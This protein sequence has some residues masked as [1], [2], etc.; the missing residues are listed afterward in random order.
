MAIISRSTFILLIFLS[1]I[2][3][4]FQAFGQ[5]NNYLASVNNKAASDYQFDWVKTDSSLTLK[6]HGET[7][8][9]FNYNNRFGKPYF[10]PLNVNG[11]SL[12]CVSPSDHPWH[13]GLW[14]SW[15]YIDG[16]NYWEYLDKYKSGETG[17]QSE[18]IT[19]IKKIKTI[20]H[21]DFSAD[22]QL[23]INYQAAGCNPALTE[24]RKLHLSA[25]SADGS[26]YIDQEHTF[27]ALSD[28]V[29]LDRTPTSGEPGGFAWGGYAGLSVRFSQDLRYEGMVTPEDTLSYKKGNWLYMGFTTLTKEKVG[30]AVFQHPD[31]TTGSTGW[32]VTKDPKIRFYFFSPAVLFDRKIVLKKGALIQL[33]Y[34]IWL[35]AGTAEKEE[36]QHKSDAFLNKRK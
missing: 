1:A 2:G 24:K 32:Y 28:S 20:S 7:I 22:L 4:D 14:F 29:L 15:K 13:L 25:P 35:L 9:Q 27:S 6:N 36:L 21:P 31:F 30:I 16:V 18:G 5:G 8:W 12:T 23:T 10:H 33:K 19:S 26:Y 17:Y 11:T 34:R 3:S